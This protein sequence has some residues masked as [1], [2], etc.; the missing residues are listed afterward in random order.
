MSEY[1]APLEEIRFA[2]ETAGGMNEWTALPGFEEAGDDLVGA[3]LDEA[4][5]LASGVIAPTN[6]IGDEEGLTLTDDTVVTPEAFKPMHQAF[7]EGGWSTLSADPDLGGQGLPN[8]LSTA[9]TEMVTSANMAYSLLPLLTAGAIEAIA[10]HGTEEQRQAYLPNMI[11]GVWSGAMNLTEPSAGSDVGALRAKAEPM[12]D[13]TYR[14]SGQKIFITW[15]DHDLAE[16]VIH[17]VLARLPDAPSGTKGISMFIVPKFLLNEDGS[18]GQ[19]NDVKCVSL[20]H[21]LGIHASP[22]CVMSFGDEGNC[23]GYL[24]GEENR[25][26][27]NMFTMMNHARVG[28][29]L[30]GTAIAERAYQHAAAYALDRVQS[31]E[32]GSASRESVAIIRHPDVRKMLMTMRATAEA[33]RAIIYRNVWALDRAHKAENAD[34]KASAK[35]EADL[36]TP[37][38]KAYATDIGVEAASLGVQ[39]CGGMGFIEETGVAQYYRDAR[40]APIYEGTNG[41]QALDLVGRKLN[42]DGGRHWKALIA[43]MQ[44]YA[45]GPSGNRALQEGVAALETAANTLMANGM[46]RIVDTAGAATAYLRLFGTVLGAYMLLA[47]AAEAEK[48]LAEGQGNAAFL[49]AKVS[50]A[51]FYCD[52]ILPSATA[53]LPS[54]EAGARHMMDM[55]DEDFLRH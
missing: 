16:N 36:L 25:G 49:K 50:T 14:I 8:T 45:D 37:I 13:G 9:V 41:I 32:L 47:Q 4:G 12:P 44:A 46:D 20:E 5:K 55:A 30:E 38:S 31:A 27:A 28:V 51:Q 10:A 15:G 17:L 2:L 11:T 18:C 6:R 23:V 24:V 52:H 53:L 43:E 1:R 39:V 34:E 48:R 35:G 3:I 7:V 19:R 26:M 40:I 29:G 33:S 42:M 22:T 21:K 54:I